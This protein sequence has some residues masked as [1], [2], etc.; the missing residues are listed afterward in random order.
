M[1]PQ[2]KPRAKSVANHISLTTQMNYERADDLSHAWLNFEL[3]LP[4]EAQP[5]G[6]ANPF[7]VPR[8]NNPVERLQDELTSPFR[9]PPKHFLSGNRGSGKSNELRRLAASESIRARFWPMYF[10]IRDETDINNLDY[11]DVLLAVGGRMYREYRAG[12]NKIPAS[13]ETELDKWRGRVM[14]MIVRKPRLG[15]VEFDGGLAAFFAHLGLRIKLEPQTRQEL[16]QVID[17]DVSQLVEVINEIATVIRR[18]SNRVPLLLID[19]LDKADPAT[20][21][22]IFHTRSETMLA[23]DCAIVYT[24]S[25]ALFYM[26]EFESIRDHAVF[27]PNVQ[28]WDRKTQH[29]NL[30]G[31][32]T[33]R[34][35][36][37][38]RINPDLIASEALTQAIY[39]SGGSFR[40]LSR[41]LRFA[42]VH[43]HTEG[44]I[45]LQHVLDAVAEIRGE[46]RRVLTLEQRELLRDAHIHNHV[47][48]PAR[49]IPLMQMLAL[50]EYNDREPWCDVHPAILELLTVTS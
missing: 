19:D 30:E 27:L 36:A 12:G 21:K 15:E 31:F 16:R 4:L 43:A 46:Y 39:N 26:P 22:A 5:D 45:G 8:P 2:R 38:V 35:M 13:L 49:A 20:T 7:Y 28:L 23:P 18:Q 17:Q 47:E 44:K 33:M 37:L 34:S 14:E 48:Q 50:M 11:K 3:D 29:Y 32:E 24:V 6:G 40:E 41:M 25:D 42:I 1:P 9:H 10:S